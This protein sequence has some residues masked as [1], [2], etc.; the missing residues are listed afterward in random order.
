VR[1]LADPARYEKELRLV[2]DTLARS[3]EPHWREFLARWA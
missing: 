2:R 1:G 3:G